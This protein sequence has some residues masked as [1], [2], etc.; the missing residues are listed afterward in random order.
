MKLV[1][2]SD[3]YRIGYLKTHG[4]VTIHTSMAFRF[5]NLEYMFG[6]PTSLS[7]LSSHAAQYHSVRTSVNYC[8]YQVPYQL[9]T[10]TQ[11]TS[12][13]LTHVILTLSPRHCHPYHD[14]KA[15]GVWKRLCL[16]QVQADIL[17]GGW[18]WAV[19]RSAQ[20]ELV[21]ADFGS[22]K[23]LALHWKYTGIW[24]FCLS[25]SW[26]LNQLWCVNLDIS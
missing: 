14:G 6:Y 3:I 12:S 17:S 18:L 15:L 26:W 23:N 7:V 1:V 16:Q 19:L 11:L 10:L 5:S 21:M 4:M 20:T 9:H 22:I 13:Q 2:Y 24:K 25:I 8:L